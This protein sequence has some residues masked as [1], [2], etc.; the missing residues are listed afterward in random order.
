MVAYGEFRTSYNSDPE[1]QRI[2]FYGIR[3]IIETYI[4]KKWT[5]EDLNKA[6]QFFSTHMY[7]KKPYPFPRELF[8]KVSLLNNAPLNDLKSR[9]HP[10]NSYFNFQPLTYADYPDY[11]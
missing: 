1:D 4:A 8:L 10:L 9:F 6:E 5:L 11:K 2:L 3:F 7:G